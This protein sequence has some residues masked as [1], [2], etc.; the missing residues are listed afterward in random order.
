M[1]APID[2]PDDDLERAEDQA[3]EPQQEKRSIAPE[4]DPERAEELEKEAYGGDD[5]A[6]DVPL[7]G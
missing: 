7:P 6:P 5:D 3:P 1:T 2:Q 4:K